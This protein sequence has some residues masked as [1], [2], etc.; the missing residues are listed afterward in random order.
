MLNSR[1][2]KALELLRVVVWRDHKALPVEHGAFPFR[3]AC[4]WAEEVILDVVKLMGEAS[5]HCL[6]YP[7]VNTDS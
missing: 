6:C 1:V 2:C 7:P 4:Q 5:L 3:T